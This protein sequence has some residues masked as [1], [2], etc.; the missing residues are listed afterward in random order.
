MQ[1]LRARRWLILGFLVAAG[2]LNYADRQVIAVLKPDIQAALGWTDADYG[3]LAAIFQFAAAISVVIAGWIVDRVN[4]RIANPLGVAAWSLSAMAHGVV[5]TLMQFSI[6][7]AALGATEAMGTPMAVKTVTTLFRPE[8]RSTAMG[9]S[10]AATNVGA[11]ITP[12]LLAPLS[13]LTGWRGAFLLVGGLGLVWAAAWLVAVR[14]WDA[15]AP[16]VAPDDKI[17]QLS[18]PVSYVQMLRSRTTWAI[19]GAKALSDQVW[20]LLLFWGPDFFHRVFHLK[21]AE[22]GGPLAIAYGLAAAGSLAGGMLSGRLVKRG[23][24]PVRVRLLLITAAAFVAPAVILSLGASS[25]WM[26]A[27]FLGVTLAAHQCVSVN[28]FSLI[29]DVS[30]PSR[31][32]S[33]TSLGALFGN[34]AGMTVVYQAGRMLSGSSGYAPILWLAGT[35]YLAAALWLW[36]W[37]PKA[38]RSR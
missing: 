33:V 9:V 29:G 25:V 7:R 6:L 30:P 19:V 11:I 36:V 20:W 12:L 16:V 26:A 38:L 31:I 5:H 3:G 17:V 4:L 22:L 14:R 28:I 21:V 1:A 2:V 23:G 27:M 35:S 8:E 24:R 15:K 10:N 18:P 13:V 34:L 37:L 32:G